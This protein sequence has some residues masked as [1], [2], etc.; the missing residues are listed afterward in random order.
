MEAA[1][2]KAGFAGT[3][4]AAHTIAINNLTKQ[5]GTSIV[6]YRSLATSLTLDV[7]EQS[8]EVAPVLPVNFVKSTVHLVTVPQSAA[9]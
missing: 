2:G 6:A 8:L 4:Q 7:I 5:I 9:A 1:V 3:A